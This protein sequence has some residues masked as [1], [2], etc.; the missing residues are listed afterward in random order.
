MN[1]TNRGQRLVHAPEMKRADIE[2]GWV[3]DTEC[4]LELSA[5][6][7]TSS[8]ETSSHPFF[9]LCKK[10]IPREVS[11]AE[12]NPRR[13]EFWRTLLGAPTTL[14]QNSPRLGLAGPQKPYKEMPTARPLD[15][16]RHP[17]LG[18]SA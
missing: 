3:N 16:V 7:M 18:W 14:E 1:R 6:E 2:Q 11:F 9:V 8:I 4:Q 17:A 12:A 15:A 13:G 10:Q 5:V